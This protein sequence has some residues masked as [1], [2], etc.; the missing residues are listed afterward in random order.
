MIPRW[1]REYTFRDL[2][3]AL[4]FLRTQH[5]VEDEAIRSSL[6]ASRLYFV[7]S[8]RESLYLILKSLRLRPGSRIGIPL[9]C[10]RF[11]FEPIVAAGHVPVFLDLNPENYGIDLESLSRHKEELDALVIV[12][13]FGYP[14]D[15][16]GIRD[17]LSSRRIPL[18]EDC[19]SS[20]LSEYQGF[21]TGCLTEASFL[22]FGL[23]KP[24]SVGG[25]GIVIVNDQEL[26]AS[27]DR[28]YSKL[29][30]EPTSAEIRHALKSWLRSVAYW[31]LPYTL[32]MLSPLGD[33]RDNA[34]GSPE[35]DAYRAR[36]ASWEAAKIRRV[37][38]ALIRQ[39]LE[40]F[41]RRAVQLKQ[42]FQM[43]RSSIQ[44]LPFAVPL[45]PIWGKWNYFNLPV[46]YQSRAHR[47]A[48]RRY[49]K[50]HG[51]DTHKMWED[52]ATSARFFGYRSNCPNAE[53]AADTVC[54]V[55][56][57]ISLTS[58]EIGRIVEFLRQTVTAK[59]R[60]STQS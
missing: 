5:R 40:D 15:L 48:A 18:I 20:L 7:R 8:G 6:N 1:D 4:W 58:Q 54:V 44:D 37:N 32:M 56:T 45:D 33:R 60:S 41:P 28:E 10:C 16:A 51:I 52:C 55:P 39:R 43:V 30:A 25:G 50:K 12:H 11:V 34:G 42:N 53:R 59:G 46:R 19:A 49:L 47:D 29:A 35:L 9:Y 23:H 24:A 2:V 3:T 38:Y 17:C 26:V 13:T 57:Y 27:V 31:K 21:P 36:S 22:S 14:A